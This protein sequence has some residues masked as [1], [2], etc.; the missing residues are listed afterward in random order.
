MIKNYWKDINS[1]KAFFD[2]AKVIRVV[3]IVW[4]L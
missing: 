2:K 3:F 4:I 1:E